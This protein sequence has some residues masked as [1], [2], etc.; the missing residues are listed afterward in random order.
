MTQFSLAQVHD[1]NSGRPHKLKKQTDA[2]NKNGSPSATDGILR[3]EIASI[4]P[5]QAEAALDRVKGDREL[6]RQMTELFA[7]Q[8]N[9]LWLDILRACQ[10]RDGATLQIAANKLKR[11]V[12]SLGAGEASQAAQEVEIL[13]SKCD[14]GDAKERCERLKSEIDRVVSA[15]REFTNA[16]AAPT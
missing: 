2:V 4:L 16:V 7:M 13:G 5:F 10:R 11:S 15:L 14:F 3:H 9:S 12:K 6:L 1:S 8:W